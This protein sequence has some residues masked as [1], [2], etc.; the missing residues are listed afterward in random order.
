MLTCH[1]LKNFHVVVTIGLTVLRAMPSQEMRVGI[2]SE[3]KMPAILLTAFDCGVS[4]I[5]E[6]HG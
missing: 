5:E 1:S 3:I 2:F 6:V 4:P